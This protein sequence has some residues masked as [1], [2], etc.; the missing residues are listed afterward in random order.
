MAFVM[1]ED[2]TKLLV[3]ARMDM[4]K[5]VSQANTS[6]GALQ[7]AEAWAWLLAPQQPHGSK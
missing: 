2:E 3:A 4:L 6:T 1:S 5:Q 7:Y